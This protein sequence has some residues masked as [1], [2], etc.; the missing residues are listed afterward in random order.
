VQSTAEA[1]TPAN[2]N[3]NTN[4]AYENQKPQFGP[5]DPRPRDFLQS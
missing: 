3:T 5:Q 4:K 1:S 2:I